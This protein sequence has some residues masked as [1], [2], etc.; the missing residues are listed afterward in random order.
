ML[1]TVYGQVG[2]PVT[3]GAVMSG[4]LT[5]GIDI[6]W[7]NI[8]N[9]PRQSVQMSMHTVGAN[10]VVTAGTPPDGLFSGL[11]GLPWCVGWCYELPAPSG[12]YVAG[13]NSLPCPGD[14]PNGTYY[15]GVLN[16]Y[17]NSS[18][19]FTVNIV[20]PLLQ[21][22]V[23]VQYTIDGNYGFYVAPNTVPS[24]S[25]L[26]IHNLIVH[27]G[28]DSGDANPGLTLTPL[29]ECGTQIPGYYLT[30]NYAEDMSYVLTSST[31]IK[32]TDGF[33]AQPQ[34]GYAIV[35]GSG[36]L[37]PGNSFC[38]VICVDGSSDCNACDNFAGIGGSGGAS[39]TITR[40]SHS[41]VVM[42]LLSLVLSV[43]KYL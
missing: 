25:S 19:T 28:I 5:G 7:F 43:V 32:N 40:Q 3:I 23:P 14:Y 36:Q 31:A 15:V 4:T 42:G 33:Y 2:K 26:K 12:A 39:G 30:D 29:G 10:F 34:C 9:S 13:Y 6:W 24:G 21:L 27:Q 41:V 11:N 35:G 8:T 38:L 16:Q 1:S 17:Q 18:Y 20:D 22:G 37:E